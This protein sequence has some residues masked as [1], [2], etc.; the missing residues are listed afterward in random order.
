MADS[1]VY[2]QF[3]QLTPDEKSYILSH[4]HHAVAI[5]ES[6]NLAFMETKRWF[7]RNGRNDKSDAFRHCFWSA[8]LARELGY[9]NALKFTTAH[10]SSPTNDPAEKAMDLYNN[11]VGLGIG[12]DNCTDQQLA[13]MCLSAL[14]AGRLK[15]LSGG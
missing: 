5:R 4:P 13:A 12:K 9:E 1:N 6:R 7:G 3:E 2:D 10:E 8:L 11:R 15:V 14:R